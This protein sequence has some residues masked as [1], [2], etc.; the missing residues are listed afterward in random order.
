M[1]TQLL[2]LLH[3]YEALTVPVYLRIIYV[4]LA[5][6]K[7][8]RVPFWR[9]FRLMAISVS[10]PNCLPKISKQI[11]KGF[12]RLRVRSVALPL[13][14]APPIRAI[15]HGFARLSLDW[16]GFGPGLPECLPAEFAAYFHQPEPVHRHL[17]PV[18]A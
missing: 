15:L 4:L 2:L 3:L 10:Q 7:F 14:F 13:P 12:V 8:R 18:S 17:V 6:P 11:V 1:P 5:N 9:I 16:T